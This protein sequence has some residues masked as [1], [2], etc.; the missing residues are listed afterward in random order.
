[1]IYSVQGRCHRLKM[2]DAHPSI[3]KK[4]VS[5]ANNGF[6]LITSHPRQRYCSEI[7]CQKERKAAGQ[8]RWLARPKNPRLWS[9]PERGQKHQDCAWII[10]IGEGR[11]PSA[12]IKWPSAGA[13]KCGLQPVP[14]LSRK[15]Y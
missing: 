12:N 4:N 11:K 2:G 13:L 10:R 9:G 15:K 6:S 7:R 3:A 5:A 14:S 1:V 8:K